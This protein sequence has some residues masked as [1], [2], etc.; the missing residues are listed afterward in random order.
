LPDGFLPTHKELS[1][2]P[3]A[4]L[5]ATLVREGDCL[6]ADAVD[7]AGRWLPVWPSG[8]T[9]NADRLMRGGRTLAKVGGRVK[10]GGG[11][12]HDSQYQLLRELMP[13]DI[14]AACRTDE[15][16]LVSGLE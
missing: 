2:Y 8:F 7:P 13:S 12:Y 4:L 1:A 15:Y 9:L 16:W 3:A 11:E 6:Y 14:P 10:L 5:D